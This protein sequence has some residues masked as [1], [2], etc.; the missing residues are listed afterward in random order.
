MPLDTDELNQRLPCR[1]RLGLSRLLYFDA[2]A[3]TSTCEAKMRR[4]SSIERWHADECPYSSSTSCGTSVLHGSKM[5]GQR[6]WNEQP[7]GTK[8]S[9]GGAPLI[10][11]RR[12]GS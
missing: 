3:V 8:I 12:Y 7:G 4:F 5:Y 11:F 9:E 6:G 10:G 1:S 2:H